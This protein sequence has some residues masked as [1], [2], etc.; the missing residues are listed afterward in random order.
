MTQASEVV[1]RSG[2]S[3]SLGDPSNCVVL[4]LDDDLLYV[5]VRGDPPNGALL[6]CFREAFET[7]T[8]TVRRPTLVDLSAFNGRIDWTSVRQVGAIAPW[9][10]SGGGSRVA[11]VTESLWFSAL[12]K[13][14]KELYPESHHRQFGDV[15]SAAAWLATAPAKLH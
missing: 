12:L 14:V 11:Y 2:S 10:R 1:T 3:F 8:L 4:S 5:V 7:G 9:G 13:L 6:A 15:Q